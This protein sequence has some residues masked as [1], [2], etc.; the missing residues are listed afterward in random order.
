M[1]DETPI[2]E[3]IRLAGGATALAVKLGESVQTVSNWRARGEPPANRCLAIE[4]I[5]GV[6]R[7]RLRS[8]WRDYWP[9]AGA[10]DDAAADAKAA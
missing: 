10:Q 2:A 1:D 5:T 3:A 8:D 7:S 9:E 4:A 6:S